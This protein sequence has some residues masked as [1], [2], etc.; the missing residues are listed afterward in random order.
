MIEECKSASNQGNKC[1]FWNLADCPG[2]SRNAKYEEARLHLAKEMNIV[3]IIKFQRLFKLAL[4]TL[5]SKQQ[6]LLLKQESEFVKIDS[7]SGMICKGKVKSAQF[8]TKD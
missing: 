7:A 5:M 8:L 6:R 2:Q 4:K 1:S 3:R